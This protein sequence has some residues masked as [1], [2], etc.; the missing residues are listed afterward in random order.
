MIVSY[1]TIWLALGSTFT[2][3][4]IQNMTLA[5]NMPGHE[6]PVMLARGPEFGGTISSRSTVE[7]GSAFKA[8][9]A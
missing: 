2:F 9:R 1:P 4:L 3:D 5:T 6:E 8:V 7:K